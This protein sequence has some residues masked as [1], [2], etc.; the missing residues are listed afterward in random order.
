LRR[1]AIG[2]IFLVTLTM[3]PAGCKRPRHD[4]QAVVPEHDVPLVSV[5]NMNDPAAATQLVRGFYTLEANTWRWTM[6]NFEVALKPPTG[7]AQKGARLS[8]R[9]TVP[10]PIAAKLGPV[11]VKATINGLALPPETY[12]KAG[13]YLYTRDVPAAALKGDTAIVAFACDKGIAPTEADAR[14][15]AIIAVSI[16]LETQ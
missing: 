14:E 12:S 11:T 5:V 15:L 4:P 13:D 3:I 1:L 8:L 2:R 16:G 9:L 10:E 7:A 6:K